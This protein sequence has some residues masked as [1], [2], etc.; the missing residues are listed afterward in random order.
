MN[1]EEPKIYQNF[2]LK[3]N[4]TFKLN[5]QAKYF[6]LVENVTQLQTLITSPLFSSE[7][8]LYLGGGSNILFSGDFDGLVIRL[9]MKGKRIVAEDSTSV[10]IEAFAGEDWPELVR[11]VVSKGWG[12]IENLA[13]VP[14][15]VGAAP[16]QNIAC[17]GHNLHE[18]VFCVEALEVAT[19]KIQRFSAEDCRFSYRDS[20]FKQELRGK[21]II[22]SLQLRLSK[23]PVLNT[24]YRSRYES[25]EAELSKI[26]K[27]PFTIQDVYNAISNI[28]IR[29]LPDI[30]S[31]GCAGSFFKN[32]T[33]NHQQFQNLKAMCPGIHYYPV[34][35][36]SYTHTSSTAEPAAEYLKIPAAWLI[37]EM[38]WAG[39]RM[40]DCGTW[41]TQPLN[42]VNYGNA[43]PAE[44]LSFVET[45]QN[46]VFRVYGILLENEVQIV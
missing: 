29:K 39:K 24:S 10:I 38:G 26:S 13:L 23:Q 17:Y 11:F 31:V 40:G 36:L 37:E 44:L 25:V 45:I 41:P 30:S 43:S 8:V 12:G 14:G 34:S 15:S 21:F 18:S 35:H 27:P 3:N 28:R 6:A 46:E 32:P 7:R 5:V 42:I 20:I 9:N 16:V 4:N 33:I 2:A 22:T 19:G 1:S